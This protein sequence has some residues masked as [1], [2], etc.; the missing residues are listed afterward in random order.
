MPKKIKFDT[1][2]VM[3][4]VEKK[5]VEALRQREYEVKC[6]HCQSSVRVTPGQ[7]PCPRCGKIITLTLNING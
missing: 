6:P 1:K 3:K 5:T 4:A 2:S 7:H